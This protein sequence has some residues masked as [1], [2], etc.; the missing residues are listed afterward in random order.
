VSGGTADAIVVQPGNVIA[1]NVVE[2]VLGKSNF[3]IPLFE[4]TYLLCWFCTRHGSMA[5][6]FSSPLSGAS[7]QNKSFSKNSL[8]TWKD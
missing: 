8:V 4:Y 6:I 5:R 2:K 7:V 3:R 1:R